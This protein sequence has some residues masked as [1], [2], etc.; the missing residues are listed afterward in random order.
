MW[1]T[2]EQRTK[3]RSTGVRA[4]MNLEPRHPFD[5]T[6]TRL[7]VAFLKVNIS[8]TDQFQFDQSDVAQLVFCALRSCNWWWLRINQSPGVETKE[9]IPYSSTWP[10]TPSSFEN[11]CAKWIK[12]WLSRV[13]VDEM[14]MRLDSI[15]M[16]EIEE[17]D[18]VTHPVSYAIVVG[19]RSHDRWIVSQD[20]GHNMA[21]TSQ[22]VTTSASI[23]EKRS[24]LSNYMIAYWPT[25]IGFNWLEIT[26][27]HH[28]SFL[29][30]K[31]RHDRS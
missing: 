14:V 26:R 28:H 3:N 17:C 31:L 11:Q 20:T 5:L 7:H 25:C 1:V 19:P 16:L 24:W 15:C 27:R 6:V 9:R 4:G 13:S 29:R 8:A 10:W 22:N 12:M 18:P 2:S 21:T 30:K 23:Q